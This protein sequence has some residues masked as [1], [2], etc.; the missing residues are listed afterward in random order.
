MLR[1]ILMS[2]DWAQIVVYFLGVLGALIFWVYRKK[3]PQWQKAWR[4]AFE[5]LQSIPQL[6]DDVKGIRYYVSPNGGGSLVDSSRRTETA[7]ESLRD[8]VELLT[9]TM[10]AEN[11]ADD[12]LARFHSNTAGEVTYV[13]QLYA[14]WLS[15]G[16]TELL[17]WNY[18]NFIH[19]DDVERVRTHWDLCRAESRQFRMA[20]KLQSPNGQVFRVS[21]I[22]TPV[23]EGAGVKRWIGNLRRVD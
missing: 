11:D 19:S 5:G 22:A 9:H 16:K 18:L 7:V 17:G 2:L 6:R 12:D 15:V 21:V 10:L 20:Y 8:Q 23:P 13:N 4:S 3:F 1:D 14:R